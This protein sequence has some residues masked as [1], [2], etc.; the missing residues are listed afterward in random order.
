MLTSKA[1]ATSRSTK[2][3]NVSRTFPVLT[4]CSIYDLTHA[5]AGGIDTRSDTGLAIPDEESYYLRAMEHS[6]RIGRS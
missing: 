5:S 1:R 6:A 2:P 3:F 4:I